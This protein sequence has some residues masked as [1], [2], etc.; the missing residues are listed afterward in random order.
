MYREPSDKE[1]RTQATSP[2][3]ES[4]RARE[5]QRMR[6]LVQRVTAVEGLEHALTRF[7]DFC[8]RPTKRSVFEN[9]QS[10]YVL[11]CR[12]Q[13]VAYFGIRGDITDVLP[14]IPTPGIDTWA[15]QVAGAVQ[16]HH[17]R[18]RSAD[19]SLIPAPSL[20]APGIRIEWDLPQPLP[21][22]VQEPIL[23]PS[24]GWAIYQRC[25]TVPTATVSVA[26]ARAKYHT[27]LSVTLDHTTSPAYYY[28]AP[29]P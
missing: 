5:E 7:T 19:G 15:Q 26:A 21:R 11:E 13:T 17:T 27:I 23:C 4:L 10:P 14:R 3:A 2:E 28:T 20:Q 18:G 29:R 22:Q 6:A 8:N 9:Y 1:L 16:Y 12:M 24:D 25:T